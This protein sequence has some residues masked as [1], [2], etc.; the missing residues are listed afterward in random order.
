MADGTQMQWFDIGPYTTE[1]KPTLS[2]TAPAE[3]V[4]PIGR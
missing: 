3:S 4:S 2:Q 1:S